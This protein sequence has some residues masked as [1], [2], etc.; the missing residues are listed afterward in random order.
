M[1]P[2]EYL[3]IGIQWENKA[4]LQIYGVDIDI[5]LDNALTG[6]AKILSNQEKTLLGGGT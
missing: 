6:F 4:G 3:K 1:Q 5:N 2:R